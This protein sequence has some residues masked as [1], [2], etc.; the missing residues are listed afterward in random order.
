MN[1]VAVIESMANY[2]GTTLW[3]LCLFPQQKKKIKNPSLL[4]AHQH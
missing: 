4:R 1:F 2:A 3:A